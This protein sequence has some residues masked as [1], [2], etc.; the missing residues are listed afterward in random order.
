MWIVP[1]M[2]HHSSN[3]KSGVHAKFPLT[4]IWIFLASGGQ[5]VWQTEDSEEPLNPEQVYL[6]YCEGNGIYGTWE[7]RDNILFVDVSPEKTKL[8]DFY[9]WSDFLKRH[10]TPPTDIDIWRPFFWLGRSTHTKDEY[11]WRGL[12]DTVSLGA[13]GSVTK[14]WDYLLLTP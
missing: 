13:F 6:E 11:G 12:T 5:E 1:F 14:V 9:T 10:Q 4:M 3:L 8:S 2:K 7:L